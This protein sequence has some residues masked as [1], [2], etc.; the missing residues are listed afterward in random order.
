MS[1]IGS[2]N[3]DV[4]LRAGIGPSRVP[5]RVDGAGSEG[6]AGVL[7]GLVGGASPRPGGEKD[8]ARTAAEQFVALSLVHPVLK[9]MRESNQAWGPFAPSS[10]EKQFQALL[11]MR[12]S[13]SIV[14]SD[15]FPLVERVAQ[16]L[17]KQSER[18]GG[19]A[20]GWRE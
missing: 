9:Q 11:D 15:R 16:G 20:D 8:G 18:L 6:F 4:G 1:A 2:I 3:T 17:R 12:L 5:E 10:G 13:D 7:R 19:A 14:R